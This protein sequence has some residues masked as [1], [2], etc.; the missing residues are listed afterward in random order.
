[1]KKLAI[2]K[3]SNYGNYSSDNYSGHCRTVDLGCVK[4]YYSYD[5]IVAYSGDGE[6]VISQNEWSNTTG[7]HLNWIDDD[8]KKRVPHTELM[9]KLNKLLDKQVA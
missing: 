7:K 6:F 1:M 9:D 3:I 5:T 4:L 8:K 2:P